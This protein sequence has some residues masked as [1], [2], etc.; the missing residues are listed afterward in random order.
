[1]APHPLPGGESIIASSYRFVFMV[2]KWQRYAPPDG[3]G[4]I[5]G[6]AAAVSDLQEFRYAAD[7]DPLFR[8]RTAVEIFRN[9]TDTQRKAFL[10]L[11]LFKP[12]G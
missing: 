12:R 5:V 11:L 6:F 4:S 9:S 1:L 10:F 7:Y 2:T 8:G 3:F